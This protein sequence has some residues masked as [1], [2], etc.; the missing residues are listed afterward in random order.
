MRIKPKSAAIIRTVLS[1]SSIF[2]SK[3]SQS[4]RE[5][6]RNTNR[7]PSA[8]SAFYE[9]VSVDRKRCSEVSIQPQYRDAV[10]NSNSFLHFHIRNPQKS[11]EL[12][13]IVSDIPKTTDSR[14]ERGKQN[15]HP[16]YPVRS[17]SSSLREIHRCVR[18]LGKRPSWQADD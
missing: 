18:R 2:N 16:A 4:C 3:E 5:S 8:V 11:A 14:C 6:S 10:R 7:F 1:A 13:H 9:A 12:C 17:L 15:R